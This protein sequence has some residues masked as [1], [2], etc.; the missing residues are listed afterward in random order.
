MRRRL[1]ISCGF[2][3]FVL[4]MVPQCAVAGPTDLLDTAR[5]QRR[6]GAWAQART[7][8]D[9]A[10]T[11]YPRSRD[12]RVLLMDTYVKLLGVEVN[13]QGVTDT[14]QRMLA[15]WSVALDQLEWCMADPAPIARE[16]VNKFQ[17]LAEAKWL[18]SPM[19]RERSLLTNQDA[20]SR[21]VAE[22]Q[23]KRLRAGALEWVR[24]KATFPTHGGHNTQLVNIG[25]EMFLVPEHWSGMPEREMYTTRLE[26]IDIVARANPWFNDW[27]RFVHPTPNSSFNPHDTDAVG[28]DYERYLQ[29]LQKRRY[30]QLSMFATR[31][32]EDVLRLRATHRADDESRRRG[33]DTLPPPARKKPKGPPPHLELT[34]IKIVNIETG[35]RLKP[36]RLIQCGDLG[37]VFHDGTHVYLLVTAGKARPIIPGE[38]GHAS[39]ILGMQWGGKYLWVA[40]RNGLIVACEPRSGGR[41]VWDIGDK[42]ELRTDTAGAEGARFSLC[43]Y[44]DRVF[45]LYTQSPSPQ[46][47][48]TWIGTV[49]PGEAQVNV[50]FHG[51]T[52]ADSSRKW[53]EH[54][55]DITL[56]FRGRATVLRTGAKLDQ[57]R[58]LVERSTYGGR[59]RPLMIDPDTL[60]VTVAAEYQ[61]HG[62]LERQV[63]GVYVTRSSG[64]IRYMSAKTH[65]EVDRISDLGNIYVWF[66][67]QGAIYLLGDHFHRLDDENR[68]VT[69]LIKDTWRYSPRLWSMSAS[70][71][72]GI[73]G[74]SR[75]E[76]FR[77]V[78]HSQP[79]LPRD[80]LFVLGDAKTLHV[81]AH[82]GHLDAIA[83]LLAAGHDINERAERRSGLGATPLF[84][85][86]V[87]GQEEAVR[88]LLD[89]GADIDCGEESWTPLHGAVYGR[90]ARVVAV[91]LQRGADPNRP[92]ERGCTPLIL[93][94]TKGNVAVLAQLLKHGGDISATS[95]GGYTLLQMAAQGSF[96][97]A[98]EYLL[99]RGAKL[100]PFTAC[101][102]GKT[103][104]LKAFLNKDSSVVNARDPQGST[105]L[106]WLARGYGGRNDPVAVANILLPYK[107]DVE[108]TNGDEGTPL[109]AAADWGNVE[110]VQWLVANGSDIDA[111]DGRGRTP[112]DRARQG[113]Y[114]LPAVAVLE[115]IGASKRPATNASE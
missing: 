64:D 76:I 82:G 93:A 98:V 103:A 18:H 2:A 14:R 73:F 3:V 61:Y 62:V 91:L 97:D 27:H 15:L 85:A 75:K 105:L 22:A 90:A 21:A 6:V 30:R 55:S 17:D 102:T 10:V 11:Q 79:D 28:T 74:A 53:E 32:Y 25:I 63:G 109:H 66:R 115:Q 92:D 106:H 19:R 13:K 45:I 108:A 59:A 49:A 69:T 89:K 52:V 24:H 29:A 44:G 100:D 78:V 114:G 58:I 33:L 84:R 101:V 34:R 5:E 56:G 107:P 112:L 46:V 80:P 83:A 39:R 42:I 81:A 20:T 86:A 51:D 7:T 37:D 95:E 104:A 54:I 67:H 48:E 110:L 111:T 16:E 88:F 41:Y 47:Q 26:F 40:R 65:Q 4:M 71:T 77:V 38:G 50:F 9:K 12:A 96:Q 57:D 23:T 72:Y 70:K 35:A 43:P 68:T 94:A 113:A 99:K 8:L 1:L 87:N 31:R 36:R 60:G